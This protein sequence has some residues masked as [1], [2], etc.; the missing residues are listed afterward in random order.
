MSDFVMYT[1][2][3]ERRAFPRR[4]G[5]RP[6]LESLAARA[7][8]RGCGIV[9]LRTGE[10]L[11]VDV[12]PRTELIR[13]YRARLVPGLER[14][15]DFGRGAYLRPDRGFSDWCS[16]HPDDAAPCGVGQGGWMPASVACPV[17]NSAAAAES[18]L[19]QL[20]TERMAACPQSSVG[21][22]V[23]DSE[24]DL[25]QVCRDLADSGLYRHWLSLGGAPLEP[26]LG[27]QPEVVEAAG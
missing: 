27:F 8:T 10:V 12:D 23:A 7:V 9:N 6:V 14:V 13:G 4:E 26:A 1:R 18:G 11:A 17:G 2:L 24:A 20:L 19:V 16:D 22:W 25:R 15:W 3:L 21:W 5:V